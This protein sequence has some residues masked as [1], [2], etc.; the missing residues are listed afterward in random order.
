MTRLYTE[1]LQEAL[2]LE[3][4]LDTDWADE[5][6]AEYDAFAEKIEAAYNRDELTDHEFDSL[7][8]TAFFDYPDLKSE[9]DDEDDPELLAVWQEE[10]EAREAYTAV[11]PE[12]AAL[13]AIWQEEH[14]AWEARRA[15]D[16]ADEERA[17]QDAEACRNE[18]GTFDW[19]AFAMLCD[20]APDWD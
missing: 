8:C 16:K 3:A 14:D 15:A 10:R 20:L 5:H 12:D 2:R 7:A 9:D 4:H 17:R 1:L 11:D 13:R 19:D 6:V 18:D